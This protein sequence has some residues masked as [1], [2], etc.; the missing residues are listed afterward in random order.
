VVEHRH[1]VGAGCLGDEAFG[2]PIIDA[3]QLVFVIE[4]L[5][6]TA[7]LNKSQAFTVEREATRDRPSIMRA[8]G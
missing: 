1:P 2:F 6:R 4:V 5:D 3:A 7:M 8:R